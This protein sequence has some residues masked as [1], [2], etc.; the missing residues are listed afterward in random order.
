M[1]NPDQMMKAIAA[2]LP[3]GTIIVEDAGTAASALHRAMTFDNG[4]PLF[5][6]RGGA[7]GWG[8]GAA[9]GVKLAREDRPVLAVVADGSAM[10]TVQALWTA[11]SL[12]IPVV[13]VIC[14]NGC[15]QLLKKNLDTYHEAIGNSGR[16]SEMSSILDFNPPFDFAAIASAMG[17]RSWRVEEP[18]ALAVNLREA[19]ASGQPALLDVVIAGGE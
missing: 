13:F 1:M 14:N 8:M 10:M 7:I 19:F 16:Q 9:L 2:E 18:E 3:S 4:R 6:V 15:Y 17:V 11:A 12:K 5:G